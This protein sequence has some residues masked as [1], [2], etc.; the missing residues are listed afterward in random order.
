MCDEK[1]SDLEKENTLLASWMEVPFEQEAF[2]TL[3]GKETR[4]AY[5]E[6][7]EAIWRGI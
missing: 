5:D 3:D 1:L 2:G 7:Q 4:E 6:E